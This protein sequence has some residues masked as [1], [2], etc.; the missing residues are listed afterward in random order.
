MHNLKNK[1]LEKL[2]KETSTK[3]FM[4][5]LILTFFSLIFSSKSL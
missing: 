5:E 4:D 1:I 3:Y 2:Y